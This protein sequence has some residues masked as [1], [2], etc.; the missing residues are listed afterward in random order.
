MFCP[1][2]GIVEQG[3]KALEEKLENLL[4][5]CN[6]SQ[7]LMQDGLDEEQIV[8]ELLGPEDGLAKMSKFN[9]SKGNLIRQAMTF[10]Q[11]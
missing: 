7:K 9:I 6:K 5:L 2:R 3:K 10:D 8:N 4:D 11:F 1:H